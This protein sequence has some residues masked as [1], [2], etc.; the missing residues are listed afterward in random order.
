[1]LTPWEAIIKN[2]DCGKLLT[3]Q[4]LQKLQREEKKKQREREP[5]N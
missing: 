5:I 2:T 4:F 1:M 3:T